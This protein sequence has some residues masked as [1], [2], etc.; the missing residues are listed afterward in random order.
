MLWHVLKRGAVGARLVAGGLGRLLLVLEEVLDARAELLA[1]LQRQ[2]RGGGRVAQLCD[3]GTRS[4]RRK[5]SRGGRRT[6]AVVLRRDLLALDREAGE[7]EREGGADPGLA[8]VVVSEG[9]ISSVVLRVTHHPRKMMG[10]N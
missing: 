5:A 3:D 10:I 1:V 4:A 8:D 7:V 6:Q 9:V 2:L